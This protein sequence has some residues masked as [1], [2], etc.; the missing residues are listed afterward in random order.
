MSLQ[1]SIYF[2]AEESEA[3]WGKATCLSARAGKTW[4]IVLAVNEHPY[5]GPSERPEHREGRWTVAQDHMAV[6]G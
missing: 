4:H 1:Y 2:I 3:Q 5:P 6:V